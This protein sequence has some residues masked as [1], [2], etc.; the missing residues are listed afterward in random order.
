MYDD[1]SVISLAK[2]SEALRLKVEE[3]ERKAMRQEV[4][5]QANKALHLKVQEQERTILIL[6]PRCGVH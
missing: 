2:E 4:K 6:L 3:L 5:V 1:T